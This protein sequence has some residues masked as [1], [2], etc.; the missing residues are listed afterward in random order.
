[1]N[2]ISHL[3]NKFINKINDNNHNLNNN[4]KNNFNKTKKK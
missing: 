2:K 4:K 1:M 3:Y